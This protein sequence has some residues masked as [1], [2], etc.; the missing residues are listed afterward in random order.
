MANTNT[1]CDDWLKRSKDKYG[2]KF[3]YS[4]V[5]YKN[6][7]T[8]VSIICKR[9]GLLVQTPAMHLNYGCKACNSNR[10]SK[11]EFFEHVRKIHGDKYDYSKSVYNPFTPLSNKMIITCKIHGDYVQRIQSHQE[12]HGCPICRGEK[13][14]KAESKKEDNSKKSLEKQEKNFNVDITFNLRKNNI[15]VKLNTE[16]FPSKETAV[17]FVENIGIIIDLI[18]AD[19]KESKIIEDVISLKKNQ[20]SKSRK[21]LRIFGRIFKRN[22]S[23]IILLSK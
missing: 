1:K 11:D 4:L 18:D 14:I 5:K 9:H 7:V 3:N 19:L 23:P 13:L 17:D 15:N 21:W 6:S 20:P 22:K 8:P 12:G 16:P 2:D 10:L